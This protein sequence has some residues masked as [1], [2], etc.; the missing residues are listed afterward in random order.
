MARSTVRSIVRNLSVV[1]YIGFLAACA[2]TGGSI[3]IEQFTDEPEPA[4]AEYTIGIGDGLSVQVWDQPLMSGKMRVRT[5]GRIT[6]PFV[7]DVIAAGKTPNKLASD[8]ET[9]LKSVV[10]NPRVTVSIEEARP[11]TISV[12]GEVGKP[13]TV[14]L[15]RDTG[16]AQA[17]AAAGGFTTFAHKDR[18]Y[19]VRSTPKPVRL[20]VTY[21]ALTKAGPAA[22]FRLKP[23]DIVVVE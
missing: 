3:P 1:C 5:D 14:P 16:V 8:I 10:L 4:S 17:I 13:G 21:D 18:I 20:R 22:A 23:G 7:N 12:L 11:L 2:S 6:L 19:V 9:G 15:D